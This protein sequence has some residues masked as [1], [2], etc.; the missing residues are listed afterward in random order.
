MYRCVQ[1]PA[2]SGDLHLCGQ[3]NVHGKGQAL[4]LTLLILLPQGCHVTT[5]R[6]SWIMTNGC[7]S[8]KLTPY[9]RQLPFS[10]HREVRF[11]EVVNIQGPIALKSFLVPFKPKQFVQIGRM[12]FILWIYL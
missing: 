1:P 11:K 6:K 8:A 10:A 9:L 7:W 3:V 4:S 2:R 12:I 5:V